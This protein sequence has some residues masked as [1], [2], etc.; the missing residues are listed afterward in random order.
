[1]SH[2]D[3]NTVV[4]KKNRPTSARQTPGAMNAAMRNGQVEAV[5]KHSAGGNA[6]HSVQKNTAKLDAE[7]DELS[8]D[9]VSTDLKKAIIQGR[10]AKKMTQS[11]L[12]Q[13]INE[14][15][16][17]IQEYESGKAIPNNQVLGKME[18]ALGCKLRGLK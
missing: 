10:T 2:N 12:G 8:H 1:M 7:T 4:L 14:K 17:I 11:Q 6:Q 3:F 13:A 15:P 16:Q 9:R 18:R 5:K